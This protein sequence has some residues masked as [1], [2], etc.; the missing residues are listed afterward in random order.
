MP[1][2]AARDDLSDDA[3]LGGRIRLLQ[4]SRG[5]RAGTDAV[6]LAGA[7]PARAGE[8]VADLGAGVGTAALALLARVDGAAAVMVEIDPELAGLAAE[9]AR[10]NGFA[11]RAAAVVADVSALGRSGSGVAARS[12][13]HVMA[14][15]PFNPET[16]RRP[17]DARTAL[18]RVATG[19]LIAAWTAAAARLLR[20]GGTYTAILRPDA[21]A[22]LLPALA[23]GRLGSP[24]LRFVHPH[25]DRPARRLLVQARAGGRGLLSVVPP[26][27][28][29]G[30]AGHAFTPEADAA[31]RGSGLGM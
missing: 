13:D 24:V 10:R 19:G 31:H 8:R 18:A 27:I 28:L 14:N 12:L 3:L 7:V 16:G 25:A 5:H 29:H 23:A 11:E 4:P 22:E 9:N 17:R 20:P 30:G 26:L 2:A 15:P 1:D 21:L 6:L